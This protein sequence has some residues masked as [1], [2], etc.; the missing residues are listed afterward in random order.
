[1]AGNGIECEYSGC[2]IANQGNFECIWIWTLGLK[3]VM[4]V[5]KKLSN[6]HAS[7]Y[8]FLSSTPTGDL[9]SLQNCEADG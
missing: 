4:M 1:M 6:M 9:N 7:D 2:Q 3:S 5:F 8:P